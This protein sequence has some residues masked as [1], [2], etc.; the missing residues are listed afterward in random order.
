MKKTLLSLLSV[1]SILSLTTL[2]SCGSDDD[3]STPDMS[4]ETINDVELKSGSTYELEKGTAN[5]ISGNDTVKLSFACKTEKIKRV[6]ISV[7]NDYETNVSVVDTAG[8]CY[9]DKNSNTTESTSKIIKFIGVYGKYTVKV[10]TANGSKSYNFTLAPTKENADNYDTADRSRS[11]KQIIY[12]DNSQ[13]QYTNTVIGLT[14]TCISGKNY[15]GFEKANISTIS[16]DDY[17]LLSKKIQSA[18]SS[19]AKNLSYFTEVNLT[20]DSPYLVY[21][22][23]SKYYL[24]HLLSIDGNILKAEVQ[25]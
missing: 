24:I 10:V 15:K 1:L 8:V 11:N 14:Y 4:A 3:D 9:N 13:K 18:F 23:G 5:S 22:N 17:N 21:K 6:E 12:F 2:A 16:E 25:Y 19:S 20:I 7:S